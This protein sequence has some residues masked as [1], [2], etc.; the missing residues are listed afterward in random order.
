MPLSSEYPTFICFRC[1]KNLRTAAKIRNDIIHI[2]KC[3]KQYIDERPVITEIKIEDD[4]DENGTF[5]TVEMIIEPVEPMNSLLSNFD[6]EVDYLD[7]DMKPAFGTKFESCNYDDGSFDNYDSTNDLNDTGDSDSHVL[8][9]S[10]DKVNCSHC[11]TSDLT[12][13]ELQIHQQK[14]HP[15]IADA[16]Q[17]ICDICQAKYSSRY[18]IRTHMKRHMQ[19]VTS[20]VERIKRIKR[21]Q[22]STCDE[23]FNKKVMLVEHELRHS[24]VS[25]NKI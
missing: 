2:E 24:G 8:K 15:E 3:W 5:E 14:Y 18:G 12:Q 4:D 25:A 19:I 21:Y 13:V 7:M 10:T 9:T 23:R 6:G 16:H 17:F 22:C 20:G 11:D 1:D